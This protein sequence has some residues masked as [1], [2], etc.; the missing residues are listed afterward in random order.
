[1]SELIGFAEKLLEYEGALVEVRSG[2]LEAVI[3]ASLSAQLKLQEHVLLSEDQLPY[4]RRIGYGTELLDHL[5]ELATSRVPVAFSRWSVGPIK[6]AAVR[7]SVEEF[8]LRNG[9]VVPGAF[10]PLTARRLWL[11]AAFALQSDERREGLTSA[12][13][14]FE[15]AVPVDGF[16]QVPDGALTAGPVCQL[17]P[18]PTARA[19]RAAIRVCAARAEQSAAVFREGM[20]R[21]YQRDRERLEAYFADLEKELTRRAAR[22]RL[23]SAAVKEKREALVRDRAAKLEALAFRFML[24]QEIFPIAAVIVEVPAFAI[25]VKLHRRK[26]S[27]TLE[28]EYDCAV[29]RLVPPACDG[30]AEPAPRPAACDDNLHLLCE[31]CAPKSEGRTSCAACQRS[32]G[33]RKFA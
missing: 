15:G 23:D 28:L 33:N 5:V 17:A 29:R 11:H 32:G 14:S 10:R 31:E 7:R 27:R 22:G 21:R 26:A 16:D 1:M 30:C 20:E 3:P 2:L 6:E 12:V 9:V 8:V 19:A 25:A 4:A 13:V 24:R 18:E